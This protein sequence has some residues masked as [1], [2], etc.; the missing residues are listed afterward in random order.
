MQWFPFP[1]CHVPVCTAGRLPEGHGQ[2]FETKSF[3]DWAERVRS[4][5]WLETGK[6]AWMWGGGFRAHAF[7]CRAWVRI[8]NASEA[9]RIRAWSEGTGKVQ[10]RDGDN[11]GERTAAGPLWQRWSAAWR[12]EVAN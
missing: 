11:G 9:P 12:D 10:V 5:F 2:C 6:G 8:R 1:S 7:G 3:S 4:W